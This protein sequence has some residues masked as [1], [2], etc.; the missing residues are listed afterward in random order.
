M[1]W[2]YVV[3]FVLFAALGSRCYF[4]APAY[5]MLFAAGGVAIERFG[6]AWRRGRWRWSL[7][8]S[9]ALIARLSA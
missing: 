5:P 3:L 6:H 8:N 1:G 4:L 7:N 9:C 2:I